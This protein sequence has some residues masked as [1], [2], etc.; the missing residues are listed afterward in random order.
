MNNHKGITVKTEKEDLT[1][2]E[3]STQ[4]CKQIDIGTAILPKP[5][6]VHDHDEKLNPI[7]IDNATVD[8]VPNE[9]AYLQEGEKEK[10]DE[11]HYAQIVQSEFNAIVIE[12]RLMMISLIFCFFLKSWRFFLNEVLF[13]K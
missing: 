9:V 4:L 10:S 5:L 7:K 2:R 8:C 11:T 13:S 1:L 3:L 6:F 12:V